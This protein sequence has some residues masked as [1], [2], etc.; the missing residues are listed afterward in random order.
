MEQID[1]VALAEA[2]KRDPAPLVAVASL[3][4]IV[5]PEVFE[6]LLERGLELVEVA[7]ARGT[8]LYVAADELVAFLV[9]PLLAELAPPERV[10]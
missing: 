9:A 6:Q 4:A 7:T 5:A 10:H 8:N 1:L 3:A 2:A